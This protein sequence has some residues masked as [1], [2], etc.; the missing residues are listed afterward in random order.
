MWLGNRNHA[1]TRRA[2]KRR[3]GA[4]AER[5]GGQAAWPPGSCGPSFWLS[6]ARVSCA[7]F[8]LSDHLAPL[9]RRT[10]SASAGNVRLRS[11]R[12]VASPHLACGRYA[13]R[14]LT[15][16]RVAAR[17]WRSGQRFRLVGRP[18]LRARSVRSKLVGSAY[19]ARMLQFR[20]RSLSMATNLTKYSSGLPSHQLA[21]TTV[22]ARQ[23]LNMAL[24]FNCGNA[25]RSRLN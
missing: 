9:Y 25:S 1:R 22:A 20:I 5:A 23:P 19:R 17:S 13:G 12:L 7:C 8:R 21:L 2:G 15:V 14:Q 11:S 24:A 18:S 4:R 16:H 6:A 10:R 3:F